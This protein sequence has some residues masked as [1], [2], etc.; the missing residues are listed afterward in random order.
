[1]DKRHLYA[2]FREANPGYELPSVRTVAELDKALLASESQH[3]EWL[4]DSELHIAQLFGCAGHARMSGLFD[5]VFVIADLR[6]HAR[7][8]PGANGRAGQ[9]DPEPV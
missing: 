2:E 9:A 8:Q 7:I 6:V 4:A 5:Y 1:M 3:P